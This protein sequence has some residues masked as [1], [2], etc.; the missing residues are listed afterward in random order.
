[1][2]RPLAGFPFFLSASLRSRL[3]FF[4]ASSSAYFCTWFAR[5]PNFFSRRA[6]RACWP[7]RFFR[8]FFSG[9][10]RFLSQLFLYQSASGSGSLPETQ[11][12]FSEGRNC[13]VSG[14]ADFFSFA[15]A[16]FAVAVFAA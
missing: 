16:G 2:Q 4:S 9:G 6:R 13:E 3:A 1:M 11:P 12:A 7:T 5:H 14:G 15:G 8:S 10:S